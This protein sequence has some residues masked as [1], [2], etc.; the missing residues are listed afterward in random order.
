MLP[1]RSITSSTVGVTG[2]NSTTRS[3]Q[4]CGSRAAGVPAEAPAML[5]GCAPKSPLPDTGIIALPNGSL[6]PAPVDP[7]LASFGLEL[8]TAHPAI[9][10]PSKT[11]ATHL[12]KGE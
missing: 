6:P 2:V 5:P 10:S 9:T 4:P 3:L 8:E 1:E 7:F 11:A 12:I